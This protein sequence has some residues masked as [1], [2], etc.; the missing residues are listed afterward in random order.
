M[1]L[2]FAL[3]PDSVAGAENIT[4]HRNDIE[5]A[6]SHKAKISATGQPSMKKGT[7]KNKATPKCASK[8]E[9]A[10]LRAMVDEL[11]RKLSLSK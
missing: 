5:G 10:H 7:K 3:L 11:Q 6:T 4:K 1:V 9:I 2:S 8:E